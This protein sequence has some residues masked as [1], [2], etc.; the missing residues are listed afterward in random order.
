MVMKDKEEEDQI[1]FLKESITIS[2]S[3]CK[4][5]GFNYSIT[6]HL[7]VVRSKNKCTRVRSY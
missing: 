7:F 5:G 6:Q 2:T 3:E 4:E 1:A